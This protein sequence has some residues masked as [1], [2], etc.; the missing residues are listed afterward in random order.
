MSESLILIARKETC[1]SQSGRSRV[2]AC[3]IFEGFEG[4]SR[5]LSRAPRGV[6]AVQGLLGRVKGVQ[7]RTFR[8]FGFTRAL[9]PV[10][11]SLKRCESAFLIPRSCGV[12]HLVIRAQSLTAAKSLLSSVMPKAI[13]R[14]IR[15]E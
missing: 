15:C 14:Q 2:E 6:K 11:L 10:I 4:G 7:G 3:R 13:A 5:G 9:C 1:Q 8:E 12:F